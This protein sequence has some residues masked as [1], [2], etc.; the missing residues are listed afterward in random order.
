MTGIVIGVDGSSGAAHAL[1]WAVEEGRR[2]DWPVTAV[3][4]WS[5]LDQHH[6]EP[7]SP[8]DPSYDDSA[9]K[10]ALD[11]YLTAALGDDASTVAQLTVC[12]LPAPAL[13]GAGEG[14]DL[15]VVGARGLGG[16]KGLL[17][18]SVSR[19]VI[20]HASTPVAVI[21]EHTEPGSQPPR[22]VVGTDGSPDALVAM[23]WAAAEAAAWDGVLEVV[24]AW[25]LPPIGGYLDGAPQFDADVIGDYAARTLADSV[26]Q[27]DTSALTHPVK[28]TLAHDRPAG[29]L[30]DA[31]RG[32]DVVVVGRRGLGKVA[33]FLL[34]S[35][36]L[37]VVHHAPCPV[38][39]VPDHHS[40]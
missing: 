33:G 27:L 5:Y 12:D 30:L 4:A 23:R 9:A 1:R 31:A 3:L 35:V 28:S 22:V 26:G 24:H 8:F 34:G 7:G 2:H 36:S 21:H 39:I 32:A 29:A 18:G 20:D 25:H 16:F 11:A 38:V 14:A 19:Q 17:L 40:T 10:A 37:R 13:L 6:V 15:V